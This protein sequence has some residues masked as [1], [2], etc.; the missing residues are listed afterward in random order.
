MRSGGADAGTSTIPASTS[1]EA[2]AGLGA[3]SWG[4]RDGGLLV[5]V[6]ASGSGVGVIVGV[7][8]GSGVIVGVA[9]AQP[10]GN[11]SVVAVGVGVLTAE[12]ARAVGTGV[13]A[14][15]VA[16]AVAWA[17]ACCSSR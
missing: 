10:T 11:G 2:F 16:I 17:K 8:D 1:V 3:E 9:V 14:A 4:L 6:G 5:A 15:D 13:L 7:L 12:T